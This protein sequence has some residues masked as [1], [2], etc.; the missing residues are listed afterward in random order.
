MSK[1][2]IRLP[3]FIIPK[4][5]PEDC[6]CLKKPLKQLIKPVKFSGKKL[7]KISLD[8]IICDVELKKNI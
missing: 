4:T 8:D 7:E 3:T 5:N 2:A 1:I 6:D